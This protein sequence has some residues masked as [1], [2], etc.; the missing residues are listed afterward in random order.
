MN[1]IH[2]IHVSVSVHINYNAQWTS[3]CHCLLWSSCLLCLFVVRL[4]SFAA[5][6]QMSYLLIHEAEEKQQVIVFPLIVCRRDELVVVAHEVVDS[7]YCRQVRP[8]L[9]F[10]VSPELCFARFQFNSLQ[11]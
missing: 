7:L 8:W 10:L 3:S 1:A 9:V 5:V 11:T 6:K 4:Q 2:N